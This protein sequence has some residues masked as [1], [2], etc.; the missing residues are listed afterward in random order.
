MVTHGLPIFLMNQWQTVVHGLASTR[1]PLG[2]KCSVCLFGAPEPEGSHSIKVPQVRHVSPVEKCH[3]LRIHWNCLCIPAGLLFLH[4]LTKLDKD[5]L[6][7]QFVQLKQ[8]F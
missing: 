7:P 4:V 8:P 6:N 2:I 1:A 5:F 3:H